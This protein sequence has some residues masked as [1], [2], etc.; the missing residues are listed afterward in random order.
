MGRYSGY[1]PLG[2]GQVLAY[3]GTVRFLSGHAPFFALS[4]VGA[5]DQLRGYITG[6][7]RDRDLL[8]AQVEYRRMFP[9]RFGFAVFGGASEVAK[10][11]GDFNTGDIVAAVGVGV[12]YRLSKENPVNYRIDYAYGKDG[13]N[14]YF[15]VGEAF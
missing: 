2:P 9:N 1:H 10:D 8:S 6:K 12:R 5:Q 7:Y 3:L 15:M 14:L 13:G 4:Q 11:F